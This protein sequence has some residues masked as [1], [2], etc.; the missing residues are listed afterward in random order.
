MD[1]L[2]S[3]RGWKI[4]PIFL[5]KKAVPNFHFLASDLLDGAQ[6]VTGILILLWFPFAYIYLVLDNRPIIFDI[7]IKV[8]T[9]IWNTLKSLIILNK[10]NQ[11][12]V[13][14]LLRST[15]FK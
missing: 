5:P 4:S 10:F 9:G 3:V 6:L 12:S 2:N 8:G 11:I 7:F 15:L 13:E 14:F 1:S